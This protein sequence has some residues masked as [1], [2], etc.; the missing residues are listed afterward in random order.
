MPGGRHRYTVT[1]W[2]GNTLVWG[3]PVGGEYVSVCP[4]SPDTASG[5]ASSMMVDD[6]ATT[7]AWAQAI[8]QRLGVLPADVG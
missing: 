8:E 7:Q 3:K 6:K 1:A 2:D 5:T 4:I